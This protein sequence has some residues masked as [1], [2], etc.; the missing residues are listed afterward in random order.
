LN[1]STLEESTQQI[2]RVWSPFNEAYLIQT[3][4]QLYYLERDDIT[5]DK[6]IVDCHSQISG[7]RGKGTRA[8]M[9]VRIAK[10]HHSYSARYFTNGDP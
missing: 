5:N 1:N 4:I 10:F 8:R 2:L 7:I 6:A 9:L 3:R